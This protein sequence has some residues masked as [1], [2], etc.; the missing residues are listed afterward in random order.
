MADLAV[1]RS[2]EVTHYFAKVRTRVQT[3]TIMNKIRI[4][5]TRRLHSRGD[6]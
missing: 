3:T 6:N 2:L 1:L 5:C 4:L